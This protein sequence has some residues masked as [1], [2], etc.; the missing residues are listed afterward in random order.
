MG[1]EGPY[2]VDPEESGRIIGPN[3]EQFVDLNSEIEKYVP[4]L[5]AAY[6]AGAEAMR[7]RAAVE[8]N[9]YDRRTGGYGNLCAAIRSLP[10]VEPDGGTGKG[11][12]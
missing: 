7:E 6:R 8:T 2:R 1:S 11:G 10:L 9:D 12:A 5:N 3:V 4:H